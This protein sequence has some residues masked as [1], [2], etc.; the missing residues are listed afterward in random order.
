MI[1]WDIF[2]LLM[3]VKPIIK[4]AGSQIES[5]IKAFPFSQ[6]WKFIFNWHYTKQYILD[7]IQTLEE[8]NPSKKKLWPEVGLKLFWLFYCP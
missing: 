6:G 4:I 3:K 8:M 5:N 1:I 2:Y 7:N